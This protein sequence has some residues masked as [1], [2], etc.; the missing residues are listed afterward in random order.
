MQVNPN[1]TPYTYFLRWSSTGAWY[2]GVRFAKACH[3]NDLWTSYFTS[4]KRVRQYVQEH[5]NPDIILIRRVFD[6]VKKARTWEHVVLKRLNAVKRSDSLNQTD[7]FA[8]CPYACG[9]SLRGKT[10][11]EAYGEQKGQE[12]RNKR[13]LCNKNKK[14]LPN[15]HSQ[16]SKYKMSVERQRGDNANAKK[17]VIDINNDLKVF[18]CLDDLYSYLM[19]VFDITWDTARYLVNIKRQGKVIPARRNYEK[20]R[21]V[22]DKFSIIS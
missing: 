6:S 13:S 19:Q 16:S 18:S 12:L 9:R 11:E 14:R 8:I 15:G 17:I 10:Y 3:P 20:H 21:K 4:S 2:Y 5:G 1:H 22:A 7:N